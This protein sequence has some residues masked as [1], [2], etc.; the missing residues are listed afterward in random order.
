[1]QIH[2]EVFLNDKFAWKDITGSR[3][4]IY[5]VIV[6]QRYLRS[7]T[8]I[9]KRSE[10]E[11][12]MSN[13]SRKWE[14][15]CEQIHIATFV[16]SWCTLHTIWVGVGTLHK[17]NTNVDKV[18]I[19]FSRIFKIILQYRAVF[20]PSYISCKCN[21]N[22]IRHFANSLVFCSASCSRDSVVEALNDQMDY[23]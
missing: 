18:T 22:Q 6:K 9:R 5:N 10:N 8:D 11:T 12:R 13:T 20:V 23:S 15:N 2:N 17:C 19:T 21:I 1:M 4:C 16:C 7:N 3:L 14:R